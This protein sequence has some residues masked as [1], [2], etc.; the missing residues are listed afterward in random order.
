MDT[1]P[2]AMQ[3]SSPFQQSSLRHVVLLSIALAH[4]K[5]ELIR[6]VHE[7]FMSDNVVAQGVCVHPLGAY[8]IIALS[9]L[10]SGH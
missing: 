6:L 2:L 7:Y 10:E 9:T 3:S 4:P 5:E 8:L 1:R